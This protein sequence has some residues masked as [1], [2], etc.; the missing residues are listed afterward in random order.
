MTNRPRQVDA[1]AHPADVKAHAGQMSR[2][3]PLGPTAADGV[4][5]LP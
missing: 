4:G 1:N 2:S 5:D 3:V